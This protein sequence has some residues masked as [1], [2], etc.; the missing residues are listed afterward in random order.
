MKVYITKN[1]LT[2][3]K[4]QEAEGEEHSDQ[5]G[6]KYFIGKIISPGYDRIQ[7]FTAKE[8]YH[9]LAEANID[10]DLRVASGIASHEK[11][12]ERLKK[13]QFVTVNIEA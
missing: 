7:Y 6:K 13:L 4:I 10:A 11:S 2:T 8:Y 12:I 5:K 9:N 3:K 1:V